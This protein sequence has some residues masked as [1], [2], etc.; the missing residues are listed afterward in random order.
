M[1]PTKKL[2][3]PD[4]IQEGPKR[5]ELL[6]CSEGREIREQIEKEYYRRIEVLRTTL[7]I[8]EIPEELVAIKPPVLDRTDFGH[9]RDIDLIFFGS[10]E[11]RERLFN[12]L[13]FLGLFPFI[14]SFDSL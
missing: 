4:S 5:F 3:G 1:K 13:N 12:T 10:R 2:E 7:K 14:I 11:E 6:S 8:L 9:T